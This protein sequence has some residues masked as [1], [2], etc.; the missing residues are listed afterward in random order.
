MRYITDNLYNFKKQGKVPYPKVRL[1]KEISIQ[2][3]IHFSTIAIN[4]QQLRYGLHGEEEATKST[5]IKQNIK[6]LL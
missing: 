6:F 1:I 3:T 5:N 4:L 2:Q